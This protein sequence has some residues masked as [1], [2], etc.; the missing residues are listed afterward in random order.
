M[1]DPF[2]KKFSIWD[3]VSGILLIVVFLILPLLL[4]LIGV[5]AVYSFYRDYLDFYLIFALLATAVSIPLAPIAVVTGFLGQLWVYEWPLWACFLFWF[6][7]VVVGLLSVFTDSLKDIFHRKNKPTPQPEP[8][9]ET[10]EAEFSPSNPEEPLYEITAP[11]EEALDLPILETKNEPEPE[12]EPLNTVKLPSGQNS[13]NLSL[14]LKKSKRRNRILLFALILVSCCLIALLSHVPISTISFTE[15][16]EEKLCSYDDVYLA[17][18]TAYLE[19]ISGKQFLVVESDGV[20]YMGE[21]SPMQVKGV[22]K[23]LEEAA[24]LA[25]IAEGQTF[26]TT[27]VAILTSLNRFACSV[28]Y[29]AEEISFLVG[30]TVEKEKYFTLMGA[31]P[32]SGNVMTYKIS[33]DNPVISGQIKTPYHLEDKVFDAYYTPDGEVL[34]LY[35][36]KDYF[37]YE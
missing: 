15:N 12:P 9:A 2:E 27:G 29:I 7:P 26:Y 11:K 28:P 10:L 36:K 5:A 24:A 21:V 17:D 35:E 23:T 37:N 31:P 8:K 13:D 1:N 18:E 30:K 33:K 4:G 19:E 6:W 25:K 32:N 14:E 34:S 16:T 20:G 3:S 22:R